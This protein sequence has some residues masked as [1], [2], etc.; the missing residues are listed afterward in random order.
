MTNL[1]FYD[2][3]CSHEKTRQDKNH[4]SDSVDWITIVWYCVLACLEPHL[5]H[6]PAPSVLKFSVC[7]FSVWLPS[8]LHFGPPATLLLYCFSSVVS[9]PSFSHPI[10]A[11]VSTPFSFAVCQLKDF[12]N[13]SLP[14]NVLSLEVPATF[15]HICSFLH[16]FYFLFNLFKFK[17]VIIITEESGCRLIPV[18]NFISV[19]SSFFQEKKKKILAS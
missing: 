6:T 16:F 12:F 11:P 8:L 7:H 17:M 19:V 10:H 15:L 5:Q 3:I 4:M 2:G 18:L 13:R 9:L 14:I 1:L